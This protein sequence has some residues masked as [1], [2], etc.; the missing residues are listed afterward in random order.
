MAAVMDIE[1]RLG[2]SYNDKSPSLHPEGGVTKIKA[3]MLVAIRPSHRSS[4]WF[5]A[6]VLNVINKKEVY[7]KVFL[8]DYGDVLDDIYTR[9]MYA[10]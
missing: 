2:E 1:R 7:I 10:L 6:K 9:Y 5:R 8:I 4:N 3:G